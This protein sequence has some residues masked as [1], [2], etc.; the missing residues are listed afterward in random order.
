M[1]LNQVTVPTLNLEAGIAFYE[2]LGLRLIVKSV[3]R[4]ARFECPDG[5]ATFSLHLVDSLPVGSGT[6]VYFELD[7]LDHKVAALQSAGI[8]FEHGPVDQT[9]LWREARLKDPDGNQVI[10]YNAGENRRFPPWRIKAKS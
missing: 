1:N 4:Y 7:Q 5:E 3:P 9:W 10:L 2:A 6:I 8:Q